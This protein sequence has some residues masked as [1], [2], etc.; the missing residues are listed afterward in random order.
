MLHKLIKHSSCAKFY[1]LPLHLFC[2]QMRRNRNHSHILMAKIGSY[3]YVSSNLLP[4]LHHYISLDFVNSS[5]SPKCPPG[6]SSWIN[7]QDDQISNLQ[8]MG[9]VGFC[10]SNEHYGKHCRKYSQIVQI[11]KFTHFQQKD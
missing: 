8:D 10:S 6:N 3:K 4:K 11:S 9:T 7:G 2:Q 1:T 5:Q